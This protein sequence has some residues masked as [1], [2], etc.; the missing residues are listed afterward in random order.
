MNEVYD[1]LGLPHTSEG[2][3]VGWL[4]APADPVAAIAAGKQVGDGFIDFGV[5]GGEGRGAREFMS[6]WDD[7]IL[8]DFNVDG[9]VFDKI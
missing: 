5:F 8:L 1:A 4:K 2:C 7:K 3:L 6:S 9:V